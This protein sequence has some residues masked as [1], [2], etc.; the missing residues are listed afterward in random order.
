MEQALDCA[1]RRCPNTNNGC[2]IT[3]HDWFVMN[4]HVGA[5][6]RLYRGTSLD[7]TRFRAERSPGSN[8]SILVRTPK[9]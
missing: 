9:Q 8:E 3:P 6:S 4:F 5:G 2:V 1:D 7:L